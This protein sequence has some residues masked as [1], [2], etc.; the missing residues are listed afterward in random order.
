MKKHFLGKTKLPQYSIIAN[1]VFSLPFR[2][3]FSLAADGG[4]P[5]PW[6]NKAT[7]QVSGGKGINTPIVG[8]E[9]L[10]DGN[11]ETDPIANWPNE[12]AVTRT[13][14]SDERTGG[15]GSSALDLARASGNGYGVAAQRPA[16]QART[17]YRFSAW[18]KN[19]N[20]SDLALAPYRSDWSALAWLDYAGLT[21][22][23]VVGVGR[24]NGDDTL[25]F[26]LELYASVNGQHG[27]WDDVS[28]KPITTK[29]LFTAL[30]RCLT[31]DVIC[32]AAWEIPSW[33]P[34]GVVVRLDSA[35]NPRNFII[36]YHDGAKRDRAGLAKCV[37]GSYTQ[38]IYATVT[39]VA[40]AYVEVRVS[41]SD[42][43]LYYN[44]VQVGST[45]T[46]AD[47]GIVNN[48][49]HG[50]FSTF[51]GNQVSAFSLEAGS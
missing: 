18:L 19:I 51:E 1:P 8:A 5:Y 26:Y 41:G 50:L 25:Y 27:R 36:G 29:T 46:V 16:G 20:A 17:W 14:V 22:S 35:A 11:M 33:A 10:T 28:M 3:D 7:W 45:Q 31:A 39:H 12:N 4:M 40:G 49:I 37:D 34:A 13:K 2:Q 6:R 15:T 23:E 9:I 44:G 42:V 48:R 43:G 38:L 21:W 32:K 24:M 47:A 30:P